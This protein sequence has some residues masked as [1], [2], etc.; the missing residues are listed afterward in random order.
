MIDSCV[1]GFGGFVQS[2]VL[3]IAQA[4][5]ATTIPRTPLCNALLK[6]IEA[7]QEQAQK[8]VGVGPASYS[9]MP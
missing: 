4:S 8:G 5:Q 3:D 1:Y 9:P 6:T 2:G 7:I